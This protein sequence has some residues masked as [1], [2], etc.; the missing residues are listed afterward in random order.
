VRKGSEHAGQICGVRRV[1][2]DIGELVEL[3][4]LAGVWPA[5]LGEV[6]VEELEHGEGKVDVGEP[7]DDG[8]EM[9]AGGVAVSAV[10]TANDDDLLPDGVFGV[11]G[12]ASAFVDVSEVDVA[13]VLT[14]P[15]AGG[16]KM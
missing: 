4:E 6:W 12:P 13:G 9:V 5:E 8:L 1:S 14:L 15:S 2:G 3:V 10:D 7:C 16:D 11:D